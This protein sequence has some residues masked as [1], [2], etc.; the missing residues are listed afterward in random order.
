MAQL[1]FALFQPFP[2]PPQ[3]AKQPLHLPESPARAINRK[4]AAV[5][6]TTTQEQES[7]T[8]LKGTVPPRHHQILGMVLRTGQPTPHHAH[9][10]SVE[11]VNEDI[12]RV[13]GALRLAESDGEEEEDSLRR[14]HLLS[15]FTTF[16][17]ST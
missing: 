8:N 14:L 2:N 3:E 1:T 11:G 5:D 16:A 4:N 10:L 9:L 12:S 15:A 17:A 13:V 6:L 7:L